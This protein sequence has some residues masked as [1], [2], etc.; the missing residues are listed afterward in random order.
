MLII[1]AD[2][3]G[4]DQKSTDTICDCSINGRITSTSVMVFMA[5]SVRAADLSRQ[6]PIEFG[7]HLNFSESFSSDCVE[8]TVSKEQHR[9][10]DYL[11]KS[12]FSQIIYNPRLTRSFKTVF[13][14]QVVEFERLYGRAPSFFNGH[15]HMHLSANVFFSGFF[16]KHTPLR[17]TFTFRKGEKGRLNLFYRNVLNRRITKKFIST[18]HFFSI[19]PLE[20]QERLKDIFRLSKH[21]NVEIEVHPEND[22]E[23]RFLLSEQFKDM[24]QE[25]V[26]GRFDGI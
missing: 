17:R 21:E 25:V 22:D 18:D 7:L 8:E 6:L 13:K 16:K 1:T 20:N 15:H 24:L 19:A 4:K 14:A 10:I 5:D 26:L 12:K 9:I 23:Y 11:D 2:D 3:F